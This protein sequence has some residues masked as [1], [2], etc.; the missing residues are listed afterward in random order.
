LTCSSPQVEA[1]LTW[2]LTTVE[3]GSFSFPS[4]VLDSSGNPNISYYD[5][6][7]QNLKYAKWTGT[8]WSIQSVE[9]AG[10]GYDVSSLAL[11]SNNVPHI[12]YSKYTMGQLRH[13]VWTGSAW[14]IEVISQTLTDSPGIAY[15]ELGNFQIIFRSQLVLKYAKLTGSSWAITTVDNEGLNGFGNSLTTDNNGNPHISYI[16]AAEGEKQPLR[17]AKWT[18]ANWNI[19]V[20]DSTGVCFYSSI[21]LDSNGN[22]H[23]SYSYKTNQTTTI[24][25]IRYAK[26]TGTEWN[27]Q[28]VS[29]ATNTGYFSSI[30]M[31]SSNN[32]QICY[33]DWEGM[34]SLKYANWTGSAWNVQ[35]VD[36]SNAGLGAMVLH[37]TGNPRVSYS[38]DT[39]LKY[40]ELLDPEVT[41]PIPEFTAIVMLAAILLG[42]GVA[43]TVKQGIGNHKARR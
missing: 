5:E 39:G 43:I 21:A 37:S 22:P 33:E 32:P 6:I 41:P 27:I 20:V 12:L 18:G 40:A 30:V 7:N 25:S 9:P 14:N 24:L 2:N 3:T 4:L 29:S 36:A 34:G 1:A 15:D 13:A 11:D 17:Y 35:T 23:I 16:G 19:Q 31:G 8:S 38:G 10:S 26:W 42:T 28:T